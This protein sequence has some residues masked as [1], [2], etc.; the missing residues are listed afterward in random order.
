VRGRPREREATCKAGERVRPFRFAGICIAGLH[1]PSHLRP[2]S[3][4]SGNCRLEDRANVND[5]IE[6]EGESASVT[7]IFLEPHDARSRFWERVS[8]AVSRLEFRDPRS[9]TAERVL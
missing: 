8:C 5:G 6:E 7:E 4:F 3:A 1:N 9:G 2:P